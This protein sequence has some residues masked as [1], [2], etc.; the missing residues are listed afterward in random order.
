MGWD[1]NKYGVCQENMQFKKQTEGN[2]RYW[3][4]L[5][6][7]RRLQQ[8]GIRKPGFR[9]GTILI[10]LQFWDSFLL[11]FRNCLYN[12]GLREMEDTWNRHTL[13]ILSLLSS[14][15]PS[16][17]VAKQC[18]FAHMYRSGCPSRWSIQLFFFW[19]MYFP[20]LCIYLAMEDKKE[21]KLSTGTNFILE[22]EVG[23]GCNP[24][25]RNSKRLEDCDVVWSPSSWLEISFFSCIVVLGWGHLNS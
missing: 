5:S 10:L 9:R 23:G 2:Y 24:P 25:L 20:W 6:K 7:I 1:G 15:H 21:V 19:T 3:F 22:S 8:D 11:C 16:E 12:S 13:F 14:A 17:W 4:E 18:N